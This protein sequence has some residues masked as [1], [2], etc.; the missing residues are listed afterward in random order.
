M[1]PRRGRGQ[2][3]ASFQKRH[4]GSGPKEL[5]K[6]FKELMTESEALFL[7]Q[8][9]LSSPR[10]SLSL[11]LFPSNNFGSV[12]AVKSEWGLQDSGCREHCWSLGAYDSRHLMYFRVKSPENCCVRAER[13]SKSTVTNLSQPQCPS[14]YSG[15]LIMPWTRF[16]IL[17]LWAASCF[18]HPRIFLNKSSSCFPS[19]VICADS[20]FTRIFKLLDLK[21]SFYCYSQWFLS[22]TLSHAYADS[23]TCFSISY[24]SYPAASLYILTILYL[25]A[26]EP[27]EPYFLLM[28]HHIQNS[29][30]QIVLNRLSKVSPTVFI[31]HIW[32]FKTSSV[33]TS[34]D[35]VLSI[36]RIMSSCWTA[37]VYILSDSKWQKRSRKMKRV[38][39]LHR[40]GQRSRKGHSG[41]KSS[42]TWPPLP[43]SERT[44]LSLQL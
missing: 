22:E 10:P 30:R 3:K 15:A 32:N 11:M 19:I 42:T 6:L 35:F 27:M 31:S 39:N 12:S 1:S 38:K 44:C 34:F 26:N 25:F 37:S 14:L 17:I 33:P 9:F 5:G 7:F 18:S 4:N 20:S 2:V 21:K 36:L 8:I 28:F 13:N 40:E 43:G 24:F 29:A 16:A 41:S 23:T